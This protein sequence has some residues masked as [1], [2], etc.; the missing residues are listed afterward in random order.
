MFYKLLNFER[1]VT[2]AAVGIAAFALAV[3]NRCTSSQKAS[4]ETFSLEK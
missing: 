1:K 3:Y 2:L 4:A